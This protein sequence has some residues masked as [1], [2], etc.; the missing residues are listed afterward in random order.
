AMTGEVTLRGNVLPIGGLK[1]KSLAAHRSGIETILIPKDN[2]K[3]L[4]DIPQEVKDAITFIPVSNCK[5]V[6]QNALVN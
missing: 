3:D 4:D 6:L 5:Q 2:T 1:E